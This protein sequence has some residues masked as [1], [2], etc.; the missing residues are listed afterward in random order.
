MNER[1]AACRPPVGLTAALLLAAGLSPAA[2]SDERPSRDFAVWAGTVITVTGPELSPGVVVVRDGRIA[3]VGGPDLDVPAGLFVLHAPDHVLMPGFIEADGSRGLDGTFET[4]ADSSFVRAS[5]GL[6]PVSVALDDARRNG[7]TT[8]LTAPP[9]RAAFSGRGAI[10]HPQGIAI[11]SMIV[12]QDACLTMSL[13]VRSG[14][15]MGHLAQV[16][17][18]LRG[19]RRLLDEREQERARRRGREEPPELPPEKQAL[20]DLLEGR[21]PAHVHCATAADVG[22]CF[23]LAREHS[24]HVVPV[25]APETWRAVDLI[26]TNHTRVIV[27]PRLE[28]WERLPDGTTVHVNLPRLLHDAGI[29]FALTTDPRDIAAQHPW[30]QAALA[31]R[32]G[33]P[34]RAALEA[35]T[36]VPAAILGFGRT[37]GRIAVGADADLVLLSDDPLSGRAF[38]EEA[39]VKGIPIYDRASDEKLRRLLTR[40]HE[41]PIMA[42]ESDHPDPAVELEERRRREL[43]SPADAELRELR[44]RWP[45]PAPEDEPDEDDPADGDDADDGAEIDG[46]RRS[47]VGGR[48]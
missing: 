26:R 19:T 22:T 35:I 28:T 27:G 4:R 40:G 5:D 47:V 18:I 23:A 10:V 45:L 48:G 38:V 46:D 39:F 17:T 42:P 30:Y 3:A 21:L 31:V 16:R 7:I 1:H 36:R 2:A 14:S 37:K 32:A 11:D 33:V 41:P 43:E 6:N 9:A 29:P 24:F 12:K 8:L 34:R 13:A 44:A 20:A 15:R 25:L